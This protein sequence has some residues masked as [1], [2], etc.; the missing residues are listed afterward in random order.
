MQSEMVALNF[1]VETNVTSQTAD[2]SFKAVI[3]LD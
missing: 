3:V 2:Y 1:A